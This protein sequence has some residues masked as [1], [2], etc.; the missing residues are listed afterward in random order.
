MGRAVGTWTGRYTL[1][2]TDV[3]GLWLYEPDE[4]DPLTYTAANGRRYTLGLIMDTDG[5]TIP[6]PFSIIPGLSKWDWPQAAILHD[7]LW[8]SRKAGKLRTSFWRSNR[9]LQEAIVALG[10]SRI[11][12]WLVFWL[13][14]LLGWWFW[15]Q[16][17][18]GEEE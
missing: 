14:T 13:V 2:T 5:A 15:I 9:L 10:W 12:A 8:E 4:Y 7:A 16:G 17:E 11:L 1:T 18:Q 6:R 3:F